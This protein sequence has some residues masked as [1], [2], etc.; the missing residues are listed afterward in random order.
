MAVMAIGSGTLGGAGPGS[1]VGGQEKYVCEKEEV[2]VWHRG[3]VT[4]VA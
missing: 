2:L 4:Y 3:C 1:L